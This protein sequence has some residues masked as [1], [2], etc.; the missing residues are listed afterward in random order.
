MTNQDPLDKAISNRDLLM[1]N[2][3]ASVKYDQP[4]NDW[5]KTPATAFDPD[6]DDDEPL[7]KEWNPDDHPREAK[8]NPAGGRFARHTGPVIPTP[9]FTQ[10]ATSKP[11]TYTFSRVFTIKDVKEWGAA[12]DALPEKNPLYRSFIDGVMGDLV[13]FS[14]DG[15]DSGSMR[16]LVMRGA[17]GKV[18]AVAQYRIRRARPELRSD[19]VSD[20]LAEGDLPAGRYL[21]LDSLAVAPWNHPMLPGRVKGQGTRLMMRVINKVVENNLTGLVLISKTPESD[22]YYDA[23]GLSGFTIH[24]N[25][26]TGTAFSLTREDGREIYEAYQA[27]LRRGGSR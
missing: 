14:D 7:G 22:K 25:G 18:E 21:I 11:V 2:Y 9:K 27:R 10:V 1:L 19:D 4:A 3:F 17:N 12:L 20:L 23:L 24:E 8:G 6:D 26:E 15:A 16:P 13:A 5:R